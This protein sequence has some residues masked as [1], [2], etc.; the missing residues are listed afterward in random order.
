MSNKLTSRS[1]QVT[2]NLYIVNYSVT[3]DARPAKKEPTNHIWIYDRSGSMYSLL[4]NL[5]ED[6]IKRAKE[7][8]IGDTLTLGWFSSEGQRNF[9]IKGFRITDKKDHALL[10]SALRQN[11]YT[12]GMTCFSEIL[13]DT[14]QVITDISF[15]SKQFALAFFTDG[16]PVVSDYQKEIAVI[17][18]AINKISSRLTSALLIG[19]GNYYNKVLMSEMAAKVGGSLT[20]AANLSNFSVALNAFVG[21]S[22][23]TKKYPIKI[24]ETVNDNTLVFNLNG[25]NVNLYTAENNEVAVSC[26]EKK[27]N[28]YVLTDQK[29]KAKLISK[30]DESFTK[31][32]YAAAYLL[33]QKTK[34]DVAID[35]L[36]FIGDKRC[37]DSVTNAFT[38]A[39]YGRAEKSILEAASDRRN[40]FL[41]GKVTNYVPP[42]DAFC[43]LDLIDL[44]SEDK[45]A[46]FY[47]RH[48]DFNYNRIGKPAKPVGGYPEFV[49]DPNTHSSFSDVVWNETKVNLSLRAILRGHI[50]LKSEG[51]KYGLMEKYPTYQF[52][53]YTF[54]K[55][56]VLNVEKLP[57]SFSESVFSVL[58]Q[59]GVIELE[60]PIDR[61]LWEK[62]KVYTLKL[63]AIPIVNR[64]IAQK[65]TSAMELC[66][67]ILEEHE[68]KAIIK[69]LKW[70]KATYYPEK[71]VTSETAKTFI[72]K[73]QAFL[74]GKGINTKTGAFEPEVTSEEP[75]DF[76]MAKEFT[77]KVK[78][79]SSLPKVEDVITKLGAGKKLT[80]SDLLV[81]AGINLVSAKGKVFN[82]VMGDWLD[83]KIKEYQDKLKIVRKS[84][85]ETKFSVLLGKCWFKE[86]ASREENKLTLGA[87]EFT[88]GLSEKKV[89]Y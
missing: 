33:T 64:K 26:G 73:Q 44:L 21:N 67:K 25:D 63:D 20:H 3:T 47:P 81:T 78:G 50:D 85:Q 75:T 53:N 74:E 87:Y 15:L 43:L 62:D 88:I 16:Y 86:F 4:P 8:P 83:T 45:D 59:K 55:D 68:C 72:E 11:N 79:L 22:E 58:I 51:N 19:Y 61:L 29:P 2:P 28:L 10:E 57:V 12:L 31:A 77:I 13:T 17:H 14:D 76:Y 89:G 5:I 27:I 70:Y 60:N 52:R 7:I 34:S 40:R 82:V 39:E 36:G 32:C 48:K 35:V 65:N 18:S 6:L 69:G 37:I 49:A 24:E 66:K 54:V 30:L 84:I 41:D 42:V 56:G 23:S 46:Y 9:I 80:V 38:N 1:I 71:E